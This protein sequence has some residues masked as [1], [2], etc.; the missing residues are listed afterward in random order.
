MSVPAA[1]NILLMEAT[2]QAHGL[3][4]ASVHRGFVKQGCTIINCRG[5][6]TGTALSRIMHTAT[7]S[8]GE[9]VMPAERT[10]AKAWSTGRK[11]A[12]T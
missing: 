10:G 11:D 5:A 3:G 7:Q 6:S 1:N 4:R 12:G 8:L 2:H 9:P